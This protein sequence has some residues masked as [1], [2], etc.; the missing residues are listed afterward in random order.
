MNRHFVVL[1]LVGVAACGG[2]KPASDT[3][4]A[5]SVRVAPVSD[6][7]GVPRPGVTAPPADSVMARDTA[8][9]M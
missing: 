3:P 7:A 5:D 9:P 2:E 8:Q 6:S 4:P 1:I